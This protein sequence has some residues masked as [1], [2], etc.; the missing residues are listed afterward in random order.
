M[1]SYSYNLIWKTILFTIIFLLLSFS[2]TIKGVNLGFIELYPARIIVFGWL[3][4]A[5]FSKKI[6]EF[7]RLTRPMIVF[8]LWGG[9]LTLINFNNQSL[10]SLFVYVTSFA[11]MLM[12]ASLVNSRED[13]CCLSMSI[14]LN[15]II[16]AL[17]GF[18]ESYTGEYMFVT[19]ENYAWQYN[20]FGLNMPKTVFFNVNNYAVYCILCLPFIAFCRNYSFLTNVFSYCS[21]LLGCFAIILTG[22]RTGFLCVVLY[23]ILYFYF[24]V[25]KRKKSELLKFFISFSVFLLIVV[26]FVYIIQF[27]D[28]I[29]PSGNVTDEA[30]LSIWKNYIVVCFNNLLVIGVPGCSTELLSSL[31]GNDIPP[32][33]LFL[34]ILVEYGLIGLICILNII[35]KLKS[36]KINN[37][38]VFDKNMTTIFLFVFLICSIC[39]SSMSGCYYL[40]AMF[41]IIYSIN[42]KKIIEK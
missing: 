35:K 1:F 26:F 25:Y 10:T 40:W 14:L 39:P 2:S 3:I 4:Y 18:K 17:L 36:N 6:G 33:F 28:L 16:Q 13:I 24:N 27:I 11:S 23:F 21:Y 15:L 20:D 31:I 42:N 22:S 9:L 12:F 30:R 38:S 32:H 37:I 41:G 5:I 7:K 29:L 19:Y 8:I 34:E